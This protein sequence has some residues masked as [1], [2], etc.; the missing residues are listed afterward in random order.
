M[1]YPLF[2][3]LYPMRS[4]GSRFKVWAVIGFQVFF[5]MISEYCA[6]GRFYVRVAAVSLTISLVMLY[7]FQVRYLT[8]LVLAMFFLGL[9]AVMEYLS[10]IAAGVRPYDDS[11]LLFA[12]TILVINYVVYYLIDEI[13][14][15]EIRRME[16]EVFRERVKYETAMYHSIS[17]NLDSQRKRT[18]EYKNQIAVIR[19]LAAKGQYQK[20]L[21]YVEKADERLCLGLDA[22]DTNHVIVNAVLN[23][24]YREATSKGMVFV[25]K[26][27]DLSKLHLR[28]ED[29][30]LILSNLLNNAMEACEQTRVKVIKLKFIWEDRQTVI[31][32][33]NSLAYMPVMENGKFLTSKTAN[34]PE[35]GMGVRNVIE[36]VKN[37]G[38][39][40][41]IDFDKDGFL[42]SIILP[43]PKA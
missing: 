7:L 21:S 15:R 27:N 37:Y 39:K 33:K 9:E 43:N 5:C 40:Y 26:V 28:D 35:H 42:F 11:L 3:R 10:M 24:K 19:A 8:S 16:D 32:V 1:L 23:T 2:P 36:T 25:L 30:V 4:V 18:H 6:P 12:L 22:I 34:A 41:S 14:D 29:V 31:S 17:E 20:L 38:G 13:M